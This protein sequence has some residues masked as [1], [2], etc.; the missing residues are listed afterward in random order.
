[1]DTD[2]KNA[3]FEE[4]LKQRRAKSPTNFLQTNKGKVHSM[5]SGRPLKQRVDVPDGVEVYPYG[6]QKLNIWE[7][8]KE[9][10]RKHIAN[11][12]GNFYTYSKDYLALAFPL[13]NEAELS[14][15]EKAENEAKWKTK[16]GF[17][18]VMKRQNWN[19]H[20]KKPAQSTIDDLKIPYVQ[21]MQDSKAKLKGATYNPANDGKPDFQSKVTSP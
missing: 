11:D 17:D 4:H 18:Q 1:M 14:M 13:V 8:Q 6:N 15:R 7:F 16:Q 12:P 20:P 10:L 5:N 3:G 19:E 2:C 21:A 9:Q